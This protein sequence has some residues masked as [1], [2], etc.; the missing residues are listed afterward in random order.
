MKIIPIYEYKED[1]KPI[2]I[3]ATNCITDWVDK[4][5]LNAELTDIYFEDNRWH[6]EYFDIDGN[7]YA[8]I[9][10][11]DVQIITNRKAVA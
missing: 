9:L 2:L 10:P 5:I 8:D 3:I 4:N 7:G 1:V 11:P 6:I